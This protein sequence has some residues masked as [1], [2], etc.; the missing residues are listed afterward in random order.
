[1][2]YNYFIKNLLF[3]S[4]KTYYTIKANKNQ[5][6]VGIEFSELTKPIVHK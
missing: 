4:N 6:N 5:S 3:S 2:V 1:M